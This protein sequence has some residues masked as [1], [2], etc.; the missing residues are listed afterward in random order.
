MI[1]Q[2]EVPAP[3]AAPAVDAQQGSSAPM[4]PET[5]G[6]SR[7]ELAV[8]LAMLAGGIAAVSASRAIR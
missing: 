7:L 3:P 4:L 8:G 5:S 1:A 2:N 6:Y